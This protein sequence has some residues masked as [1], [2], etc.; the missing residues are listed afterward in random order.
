M[1]TTPATRTPDP[2]SRSFRENHM[3]HG[4]LIDL[5]PNQTCKPREREEKRQ[6]FRLPNQAV[7]IHH[8]LNTR[9]DQPSHTTQNVP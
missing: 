3:P 6:P 9:K 4:G 5:Y 8:K 7:P 2:T 1:N